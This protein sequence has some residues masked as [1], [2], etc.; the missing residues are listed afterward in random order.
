MCLMPNATVLQLPGTP[1][2]QRSDSRKPETRKDEVTRTL[3][4]WSQSVCS[5][6]IEWAVQL[7]KRS[8]ISATSTFFHVLAISCLLY[9]L[10]PCDSI[11]SCYKLES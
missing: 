8:A 9:T 1:L 7:L 5:T 4:T 10:V 6:K 11:P 2:F 3:E